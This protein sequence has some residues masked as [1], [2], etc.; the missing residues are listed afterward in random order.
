[1]V[2]YTK[3]MMAAFLSPFPFSIKY[4]FS[5]IDLAIFSGLFRFQIF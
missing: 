2:Y 1:M 5:G 4:L 3:V